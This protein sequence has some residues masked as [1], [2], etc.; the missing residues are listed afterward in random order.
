[1]YSQ[2]RFSQG[3]HVSGTIHNF[4]NQRGMSDSPSIG[5]HVRCEVPLSHYVVIHSLLWI[6]LQITKFPIKFIHIKLVRSS[7]KLIKYIV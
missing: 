6:H 7:I 4:G 2:A 3:V 5:L 1:M